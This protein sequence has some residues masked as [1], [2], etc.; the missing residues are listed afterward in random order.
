LK[1][2]AVQTHHAVGKSV[3]GRVRNMIGDLAWLGCST[4]V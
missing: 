1:E 3:A 2:I 4:L